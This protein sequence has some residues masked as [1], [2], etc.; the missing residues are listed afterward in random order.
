MKTFETK[1]FIKE[2]DRM[3]VVYTIDSNP[4]PEKIEKIK[5][6]I[7]KR[8]ERLRQMREDYLSGKFDDVI[9]SLKN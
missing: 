6:S 1:E 2:L 7:E 4:S 9:K 3:G 5:K 8:D